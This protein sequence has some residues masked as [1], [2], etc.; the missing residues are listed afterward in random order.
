MSSKN[1]RSSARLATTQEAK[2]P[3][4]RAEGL[5]KISELAQEAQ[6]TPRAL[7]LYEERGLLQPT[8]RSE[9][10]FRFYDETQRLRL[11]YIQR[12]KALGCSLSEIQGFISSW[13]TQPTAPE[14]MR[15]LEDLYRLK[16]RGVRQALKT[17]HEV[18]RELA[19]SLTFLE[20][21]HD[22]PAEGSPHEV[23]SSC[24]RSQEE[25]PTLIRGI[26]EPSRGSQEEPST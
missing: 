17:L 10:G 4:G 2:S 21:C 23:C 3:K 19:E 20:G 12:L 9:G 26:T 14:G 6:L 16:L 22:C 7:R 1:T 8:A 25:L 13:S 18:E 24:E 15:A 11:E 5:L